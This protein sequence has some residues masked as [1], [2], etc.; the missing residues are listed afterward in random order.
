M[1]FSSKNE[2]ILR[3]KFVALLSGGKDSCFNIL[4]C[5]EHGH[6]LICAGNLFP[7]SGSEEINSFMYQSAAHVAIPFISNLL[8]VPLYRKE[9]NGSAIVQSLDYDSIVGDEV[10]DLYA[11]LKAI[12]V[13]Q[14]IC[15]RCMNL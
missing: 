6:V 5:I 2:K 13:N 9:I 12:K 3:M 15:I 1:I 4:K 10:E 7:T 14:H 11:L 8:N